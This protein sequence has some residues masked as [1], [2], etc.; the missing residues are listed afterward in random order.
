[1]D[2]TAILLLANVHGVMIDMGL[3]CAYKGNGDASSSVQAVANGSPD[4]VEVVEVSSQREAAKPMAGG[5]SYQKGQPS[6]GCPY[7]NYSYIGLHV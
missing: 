6:K 5:K 1:M 3:N 2:T 7:T 4:H